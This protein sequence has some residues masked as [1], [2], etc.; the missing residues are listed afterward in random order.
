LFS[1]H[2]KNVQPNKNT[3][4]AGDKNSS[5]I[6]LDY[7]SSVGGI[8]IVQTSHNVRLHV[9]CLTCSEDINTQLCH[10]HLKLYQLL[11]R[12][13]SH[14]RA[15]RLKGRILRLTLNGGGVRTAMF[16]YRTA[17]VF[18]ILVIEN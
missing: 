9:H 16:A 13:Q 14:A 18:M 12:T 7:I 10:K 3:K 11:T 4:N 5:E 8:K 1:V 2:L 15:H 17:T 6:V